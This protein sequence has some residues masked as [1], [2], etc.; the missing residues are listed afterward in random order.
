MSMAIRLLRLLLWFMLRMCYS[1]KACRTK[2]NIL[3]ARISAWT[4]S[5]CIWMW[6]G[7]T[8]SK[9]KG[10]V[11]S[12]IFSPYLNSTGSFCLKHPLFLI[13]KYGDVMNS[14]VKV[15]SLQLEIS[16]SISSM[17]LICLNQLGSQRSFPLWCRWSECFSQTSLQLC[18][19]SPN[20]TFI[21]SFG[22]Q[23][24]VF[25]QKSWCAVY[26]WIRFRKPSWVNGNGT[27]NYLI[28][29]VAASVAKNTGSYR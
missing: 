28:N 9:I 25:V 6:A 21:N 14:V 19:G 15:S 7:A 22:G 16:L 1:N 27:R 3:F 29:S 13:S 26:A 8:E 23:S 20:L 18:P 17:W 11:L 2:R 5:P 10:T 12:E 24:F 4:Y